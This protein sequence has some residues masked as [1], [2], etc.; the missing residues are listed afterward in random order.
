MA[1]TTFDQTTLTQIEA[2][3]SYALTTPKEAV[4]G[5]IDFYNGGSIEYRSF[6]E[7][8]EARNNIKKIIDSEAEIDLAVAKKSPYRPFAPTIQHGGNL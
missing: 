5:R 8:I 6:D 2:V 7:L 4:K 1:N 3:I